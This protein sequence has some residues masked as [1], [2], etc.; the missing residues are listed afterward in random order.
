MMRSYYR[1][2][3]TGIPEMGVCARQLWEASG[4]GPE[5]IRTAVFYDHFTPL[6]L[7]QLEEFGFCERGEAKDFV[8]DGNIEL[9]GSTSAQ[10]EG[11]IGARVLGDVSGEFM[12]AGAITASS[13][14]ITSPLRRTR[15]RAPGPS[16]F[17]ATVFALCAVQN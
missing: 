12:V 14:G 17:S 3:I 8:K 13:F 5:H 15:M 10:G 11:S 2:D 4:L 6:V 9:G 1:P 7:P 16:P